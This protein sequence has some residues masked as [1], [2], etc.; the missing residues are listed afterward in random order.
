MWRVNVYDVLHR[1]RW[2][3]LDEQGIAFGGGRRMKYLFLPI[4]TILS[5][6]TANTFYRLIERNRLNRALPKERKIPI[7]K[8]FLLLPAKQS[9][10]K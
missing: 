6:Y 5:L 10:R 3:Y 7:W 4:S 1:S 8:I 2:S 9:K